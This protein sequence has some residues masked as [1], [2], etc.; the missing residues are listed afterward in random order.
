M[1]FM[2]FLAACGGDAAPQSDGD[3]D[4]A[5]TEQ[6]AEAEAEI[7]DDP[8][9][10]GETCYEIPFS[11]LGEEPVRK[12]WLLNITPF[13]YNAFTVADASA[14][15]DKKL[16]INE[17]VP[18][19]RSV[20][21]TRSVDIGMAV[22]CPDRMA[23]DMSK[24]D[25]FSTFA[26]L[27][28][29]T[30]EAVDESVLPGDPADALLAGGALYIINIDAASDDFGK[31][32]PFTADL[33]EAVD[34]G[35]NPDDP[36]VHAFW[37]LLLQPAQL[38]QPATDYA[39][40]VTRKLRS[41]DGR[42]P[43]SSKHFRMLR[44]IEP[45]DA[46]AEGGQAR[47]DEALRMQYLWDMLP[48][49]PLIDA[50][51]IV[52]AF[53]FT[54]QSAPD[55]MRY[56]TDTMLHKTGALQA[57]DFDY[58]GDGTDNIYTPEEYPADFPSLPNFDRSKVSYVAVGHITVPEY[59]HNDAKSHK[60]EDPYYS[61]VFDDQHHPVQNG[62]NELEFF[63]FYPKDVQPPMPVT[64]MQH[65]IYSKKE[66]MGRIIGPLAEIGSAVIVIDFPFH[67]SREVGMPPLEFIDV[68]FPGKAAG[69]FKQASLEQV[70]ILQAL[71]DGLF[72]LLPL[73]GD[74]ANDFNPDAIGYCGHSLGSIVGVET[75]ALS[76]AVDVAMLNVGGG[77]LM[78]FIDTFMQDYG[79]TTIVPDYH[80]R[81]FS[82]AVQ[83]IPDAG[84]PITFV[85]RLIQRHEEGS[86]QY[87]LTQSIGDEV[88]PA[89]FTET[90]AIYAGMTQ[91]QPVVKPLDGLSSKPAPYDGGDGVFQYPDAGHGIFFSSSSQGVANRLQMQEFFD[92]FFKNHTAVVIDPLTEQ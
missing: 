82:V 85:P 79:L 88:I 86:L 55:E 32:V 89:P 24:L 9:P 2:V 37:Y 18:P 4:T 10:A 83:T 60:G 22:V 50:D 3:I 59:R 16:R 91:V 41:A 17:P 46:D 56:I 8:C 38:L 7:P 21:N 5:E 34:F 67:G 90:L 53:D 52:L 30:G 42:M 80:A 20:V 23:I 65:G 74:G 39:V 62:V 63:L 49:L 75:V 36:D 31:P 72:D 28:F 25:G 48:Q 12:P 76:D 35:E 1:M 6:E 54:T 51:D 92:G 47:A 43:M 40:F 64:M 14:P 71:E 66:E 33:R 29:E 73:G 87:M 44:G 69:S 11:F 70:Y 13:P 78:L 61:F 19:T 57:P 26:P 45:V 77:G 15:T 68:S 84:D 27:L 58:D 81:Q